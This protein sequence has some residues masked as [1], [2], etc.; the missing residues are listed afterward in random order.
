MISK[1][2]ATIIMRFI[3]WQCSMQRPT[4][5]EQPRISH[6]IESIEV[7]QVDQSWEGYDVDVGHLTDSSGFQRKVLRQAEVWQRWWLV[8]EESMR[9]RFGISSWI[10]RGSGGRAFSDSNGLCTA[11]IFGV[12]FR[13]NR[14]TWRHQCRGK[15]SRVASNIIYHYV[16]RLLHGN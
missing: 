13:L 1:S 4:H 10:R 16:H 14:L 5:S 9:I 11:L 7:Y 3:L 8:I 6:E 2:L 12:Y 15:K